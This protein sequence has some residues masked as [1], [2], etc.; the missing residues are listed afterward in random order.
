MEEEVLL[1]GFA[2]LKIFFDD[3]VALLI[4]IAIALN[5]ISPPFIQGDNAV[6]ANP[7]VGIIDNLLGKKDPLGIT[8]G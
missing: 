5:D 2:A 7:F 4:I 3:L 1:E 6:M 8:V